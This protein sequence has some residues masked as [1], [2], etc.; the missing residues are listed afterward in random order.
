MGGGDFAAIFADFVSSPWRPVVFMGLFLGLT[1]VVVSTGVEKGIERYSKVM[2]A[3]PT[4]I[5][6]DGVY[7]KPVMGT[8]DEIAALDASYAHLQGMR[9]KV[10][11][12]GALPAVEK[13]SEINPNL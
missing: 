13:W 3:M 8:A 12:L 1:H 10:I 4:R 2:M 5:T 11:E 7:T 6:S 9:D